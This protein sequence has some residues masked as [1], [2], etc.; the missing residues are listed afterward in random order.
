MPYELRIDE[1]PPVASTASLPAEAENPIWT[2][3]PGSTPRDIV[4]G[5][6]F[7][8][9]PVLEPGSYKTTLMPG[10]L[11]LY[12]V[13]ADWGQRIQ[14]QV[15]V[16]KLGAAASKALRSFRYVDTALI[17]PTGEDV[18][19]V[20]AKKMPGGSGKRGVLTKE[21]V[22]QTITTKEIRYMNRD[23]ADNQD[24]GTSMPG[25]FYIAVSLTR[26]SDD[27]AFTIP[28]TLT[29][30]LQGTAGTG[31]PAYVNGAT[32]VAGDS[33]TP[34]PT[35]SDEPVARR[36]RRVVRS[37]ATAAPRT[38]VAR[39]MVFRSGWWRGSVMGACCSP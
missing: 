18:Y 17:S 29:V 32:P 39:T 19:A 20:F 33:V 22:V 16:P 21:G 15:T 13:K 10:E 2:P 1:E 27:K 12:K 24:T 7:A 36:P 37:Q 35:P 8:D 5:S 30:G 23:G 26:K 11:Q 38:T 4:P 14:A 3:M 9:A 28:M 34:S 25:E 6:S 31:K